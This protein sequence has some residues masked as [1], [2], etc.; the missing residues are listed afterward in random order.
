MEHVEIIYCHHILSEH[1]KR[2]FSLRNVMFLWVIA[3]FCGGLHVS[4]SAVVAMLV[5]P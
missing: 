2:A 5:H 3:R 1:T 4:L